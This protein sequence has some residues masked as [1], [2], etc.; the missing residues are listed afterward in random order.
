MAQ[1]KKA[2]EAEAKLKKKEY[3][4]KS[5]E[6]MKSDPRTLETLRE[7]ERMKYLKE[8]EKGQLKP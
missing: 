7:K 3:D 8:K 4:R 2:T 5:R 6:K 1:K